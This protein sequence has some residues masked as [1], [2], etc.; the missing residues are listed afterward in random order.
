[1]AF[2]I[3]AKAFR[4]PYN[5]QESNDQFSNVS[6][7]GNTPP[8]TLTMSQIVDMLQERGSAVGYDHEYIS[9]IWPASVATAGHTV[10]AIATPYYGN[11]NIVNYVRLHPSVDRLDLVRQTAGALVH[12]H[13]KDIIH[14][15]ICPVSFASAVLPQFL[16]FVWTVAND[17]SCRKIY[18][19]L[20]TA[21]CGL[22]TLPWTPSYARRATETIQAFH[23]IGCT[24][25]LKN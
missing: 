7:Y 17:W 2:Q 18:A 5:D 22:Q 25:P 10:P 12:L 8:T 16:G 23:Q 11:G 20:T 1:M 13:S 15:N 14:G 9:P 3:M 19:S 6:S 4:V 24:N 21:Q